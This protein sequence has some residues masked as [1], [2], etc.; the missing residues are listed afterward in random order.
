MRMVDII[1]KK[2]DGHVLTKEEIQFFVNG[3]T[4]GEIPDYQ[5]SSLAMAIFFQDMTD[6]ERADLTMAMVAS[7][8]QIDL[9][10]IKGVKVDKHST[11][12]VGD[13]TTL[14]LAPLVAALDVPVAKMSGRGLGHTGGTIDKLESVE[15]FH[16]EISEEEFV[17]LVNEDHVA[18][19]GQTGNLTPADKKIYALRDVTGTVNSI[20]LIAS[21]IMS[22][23]I[24]A[25]AD[26]IVLDVK[27]GNGAFMKTVED[28]EALAHA[29]VK[30]GNQVGRQTMAIIS[31]MSQPLGFAIGNAL[32]LKEAIDTLKG[33]GPEDL[34]ELVL[35]LGSQMVVL[36]QKANNL[37]EAREMLKE[38]IE[39]GKALEKFKTFLSNQGGDASIVD[40]P[41]QL[42]TAQYQFEL[43]AKQAGV[44]AEMIANEIGIASMMLGAGRQTKEDEIDLAVG[45][46]LNKKIGDYVEEGESLLTIHANTQDVEAV[47][48]KLYD[49]ITILEQASQPKLIHTIITE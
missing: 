20:P 37:E 2:R 46:V 10:N 23:K 29:M 30:I 3:Y 12:G 44:V 45:L 43:P 27:T 14:V 33:E 25:G 15:G 8:D 18:V 31:D 48:E 11:G 13:T 28:A 49:N 16:V 17:R 5:M 22:K 7:G 9:S 36:A 4:N 39:N 35:T 34:T 6:E 41:S 1:A 32:E 19:I 24:A 26:A 40:D 38:V 42:P 47:K 21:S